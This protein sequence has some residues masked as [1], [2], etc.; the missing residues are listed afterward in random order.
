M[1]VLYLLACAFIPLASACVDDPSV[2]CE[3]FV[4]RGWCQYNKDDECCESCKD[5]DVPEEECLDVPNT[6]CSLPEGYT[7]FFNGI[8]ITEVDD[9]YCNEYPQKC[10]K[11]CGLC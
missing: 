5:V 2:D 7:H 3:N 11:T 4:A 8:D 6:V 9:F 1:R 10:K